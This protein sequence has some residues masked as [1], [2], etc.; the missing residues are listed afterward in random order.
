MRW[1]ERI[2]TRSATLRRG[3]TDPSSPLVSTFFSDRVGLESRLSATN[4]V[5]TAFGYMKIIKG[6]HACGHG[7][8][9][10]MS[11]NLGMRGFQ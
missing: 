7:T 4:K 3:V 1:R 6:P 8:R 2:R 5:M 10:G 11:V 9:D